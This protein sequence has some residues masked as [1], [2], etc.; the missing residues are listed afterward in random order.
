MIDLVVEPVT[1]ATGA[2]ASTSTFGFRRILLRLWQTPGLHPI[3]RRLLPRTPPRIRLLIE[4]ERA[5]VQ[6]QRLAAMVRHRSRLVPEAELEALLAAGLRELMSRHGTAALGDYL[7]FG[8]YNGTSLNCMYHVLAR[9]PL[10]HVRL[11]GFDSFQGF[12]QHAADEDEG[13]WQPGRCHAPLELTR[14]VLQAEGVDWSRVTL[15]PGWFA[16]TLTARTRAEHRITK[17]SVIMI[18]CDLYSSTREALT[19]CAPLIADEA[20]ILFDEYYP[21]RLHG[22][23]L[24]ERRAFM[25]FLRE[26]P[27]FETSPFGAYAPRTQAFWLKRRT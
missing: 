20:L 21:T 2:L 22:K 12:P 3:F 27:Q 16:D 23:Y 19:F 10:D 26:N 6:R 17:A 18:D 11:F 1:L 15:V 24:G 25:E 9:T 4:R 5:R 8:V 14:A 13:R 7:E